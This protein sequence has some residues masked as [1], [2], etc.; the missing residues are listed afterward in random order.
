MLFILLISPV[1]SYGSSKEALLEEARLLRE[2]GFIQSAI[3][4]YN[5]A[6]KEDPNYTDAIVQLADLM[7]S[8]NNYSYACTLYKRYLAIKPDDNAV[9]QVLIDIYYTIGAYQDAI[10]EGLTYLKSHPDDME[11]LEKLRELCNKTSQSSWEMVVTEKLYELKPG[12][13]DLWKRLIEIYGERGEYKKAAKLLRKGDESRALPDALRASIFLNAGEYDSAIE[14]YEKIYK[15]DPSEANRQALIKARLAKVNDNMS[16]APRAYNSYYNPLMGTYEHAREDRDLRDLVD[17]AN[18]NI[19]GT[20]LGAVYTG[21]KSGDSN[22]SNSF[23]KI[24]VP[25]LSSGTE[26]AA[27]TQYYTIAD[28]SLSSAY[29]QTGLEVSQCIGRDLRLSGGYRDGTPGSTYFAQL[30]YLNNNLCLAVKTRR[31][32]QIETPQSLAQNISYSGMDYYANWIADNRLSLFAHR[33]DLGFSDSN[34]GMYDEYGAYYRLWE[35][36]RNSFVDIG[37]YNTTEQFGF[38]SPFYFSPSYYSLWNSTIEWNYYFT[39]DSLLRL[40]YTYA[41]GNDNTGGNIYTAYADHKFS[42]NFFIFA[43]YINGL[44]TTGRIVPII[45]PNSRDNQLT[46]GIKCKF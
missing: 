16:R 6:L 40:A 19:G 10:M 20:Y 4:K 39:K 11:M 28:A 5:E 23:G 37:V 17:Y 31:D 32:Y 38:Q 46:I 22:F 29:S 30:L 24:F 12:D 45:Q 43:E 8:M 35:N 25:V 33:C 27:T 26:I 14:I 36:H 3:A 13:R 21:G 41:T 34:R 1:L 44:S 18:K 9:R 42:E 2:Q 7:I 15:K